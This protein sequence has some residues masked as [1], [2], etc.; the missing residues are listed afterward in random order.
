MPQQPPQQPQS[1]PNQQSAQAQ[2]QQQQQMLSNANEYISSSSNLIIRDNSSG[3]ARLQSQQQLQRQQQT[4]APPDPGGNMQLSQQQQQSGQPAF[5]KIRLNESYQQQP[6][7]SI[8]HQATA[9]SQMP[10]RL[11]HSG[12]TVEPTQGNIQQQQQQIAAYKK[13]PLP[14]G[15]HQTNTPI[16]VHQIHMPGGAQGSI[17]IAPAPGT[18]TSELQSQQHQLSS[19]QTIHVPS[20]ASPQAP[21]NTI[22]NSSARIPIGSM[23]VQGVLRIDTREPSTPGGTAGGYH[24]KTEAISPT[25]PQPTKDEL[26]QRISS[27]D[28]TMMA[29]EERKKQLKEKERKLVEQKADGSSVEVLEQPESRHRTMAQKIYAENRKKATDSHAT[30]CALNLKGPAG[31]LPLYNQ[32]SDS[33][34]CRKIQEQYALFRPNLLLHL[35][36]IKSERAKQNQELADKY[37]KLSIDWQKRV[38]K[39]ESS[40]KRKAKE[41]KNREFF[42]KVFPELRKQREDK[43][44]FNRVGSRVKSEADFEEIVDGLQEQVKS[45]CD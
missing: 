42:E 20:I 40:A 39:I 1:V 4:Q 31:E 23:S 7:N 45:F 17:Q 16:V 13:Q 36:K 18:T 33:D 15:Y 30:F 27:V 14:G 5:K 41:A 44:R 12:A 3:V 10:V 25:S 35:R 38:E 19:Q 2:Q 8:H 29:L 32:P 22:S 6:S 9:P 26:L 37:V 28:A 34:V 24:P 21:Q 43:E 11:H